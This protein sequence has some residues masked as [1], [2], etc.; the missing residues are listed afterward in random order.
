MDIVTFAS[1]SAV[2]IW[3]DKV[4][5]D[6]IAVVI[7]PSSAKAAINL[8]FRKTVS[9]EGSKGIGAWAD[10]IIQTAIEFQN[11]NQ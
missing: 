1:P 11:L 5:T 8:D 6:F 7:G 9:P 3:A 4:G 10:V 2:K